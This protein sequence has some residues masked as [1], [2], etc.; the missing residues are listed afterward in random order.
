MTDENNPG[1]QVDDS[2][3]PDQLKAG[4]RQAGLAI[5]AFAA[6][7]G[8]IQNDVALLLTTLGGLVIVALGQLHT[9]KRANQLAAA[10]K[11]SKVPDSVLSLKTK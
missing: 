6:G 11:S 2:P 1:I 9:R 5:L 7:R 3:I 10:A 4:L 8:W